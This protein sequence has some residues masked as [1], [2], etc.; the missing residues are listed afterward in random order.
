MI[1]IS[2]HAYL[3]PILLI[4]KWKDMIVIEKT[5]TILCSLEVGSLEPKK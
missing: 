4:V 3:E 5:V 1:L 2:L